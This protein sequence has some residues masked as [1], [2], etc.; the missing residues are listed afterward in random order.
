MKKL[1]V[2]LLL[3]A[4]LIPGLEAQPPV[5]YPDYYN[6]FEREG[7]TL[8]ENP[9][10]GWVINT[11]G[12][13]Q[14][15]VQYV[16]AS[17]P[18]RTY[19]R[20]NAQMSFV[21][22]RS[23][24]I[25]ST[26]DTL[27]RLDMRLV[28][29]YAQYPD[30]VAL[31]EKPHYLNFYLPHCG[32]GGVTEVPGYGRI[33]Y[34]NIYPHIDLWV[35]SGKRG[36]KMMFVVHPFGDPAQI[37]MQFT[38]QDDMDVNVN[39]WL[40]MQM[41]ERW[42]ILP[43]AVA[44]QVDEQQNIIPVNWTAEYVLEENDDV[45]GFS[46]DQYDRY[47]PLILLIGPP[48]ASGGTPYTAGVCWSTYFGGSDWDKM[49]GIAVDDQGNQYVTG[50]TRSPW[51]D[52]PQG[53]GTEYW[54]S[55]ESMFLSKFGT[56]NE[57]LWTNFFGG[58]SGDQTS[59]SVAIRNGGFT[60]VFI[61]GITDALDVEA[62]PNGDA[63]IDYSGSAGDNGLLASFLTTNGFMN[64]LTY[65]GNGGCGVRD[66]AIDQAGQ[67]LAVGYSSGDLPPEDV[68][69]P[70]GSEDWT[71]G[72]GGVDGWIAKF[73]LSEEV[74]WSTFVG[75]SARDVGVAVASSNNKIIMTGG[76]ES[77]SINN[78]D[79]GNNAYFQPTSGG[80]GS[81]VFI[82]EFN[83]NGAQQWGTFFGGSSDDESGSG[84]LAIDP[85]NGDVFIVGRTTSVN[86]QV[87]AGSGWYDLSYNGDDDGFIAQFDGIDR[88]PLWISYVGETGEDLLSGIAV[89]EG[90]ICLGGFSN[91]AEPPL[92]LIE[93]PG[94]YWEET[95]HGVDDGLILMFDQNHMPLWGTY[96]GGD[97]NNPNYEAVEH[98]ALVD[99]TDLYAL[100]RT[101]AVYASDLGL[102]FPLTNPQNGAW[103]DEVFDAYIDG[104]VAR[105]CIEQ[106]GIGIS[107]LGSSSTSQIVF[108][109]QSRILFMHGLSEG[110]H[111][112]DVF[113][114]V[115]RMVF[116][117]KSLLAK[118]T[119]SVIIPGIASG[120]YQVVLDQRLSI[121]VVILD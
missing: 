12:Q 33:V 20:K 50:S 62:V 108:D 85:D 53:A 37:Q 78:E 111:Q 52:F 120:R 23:D 106:T 19:I 54:S 55:T 63:F 73:T 66:V 74:L 26:L 83:L 115:G 91:S 70:N 24:T 58:T 114:A 100:G 86:L 93:Y 42:I 45:V 6:D 81:E 88:A 48:P 67:L 60:E 22:S 69:P 59:H 68:Q 3:S 38:G 29:D 10:P 44:Y 32:Q 16:A 118:A 72:G 79:P 56:V 105:F 92:A 94:L 90:R 18:V 76:T 25:A 5:F 96:F 21:I 104:F 84:G 46:F 15:D 87:E 9:N 112:L 99:G 34:E 103:F 40:R 65:F 77:S 89:G 80:G 82:K 97:D 101:D 116:T 39:G 71:F 7:Y 14:T 30:A 57:L 27:H 110:P 4:C 119:T 2:A 64:W 75:G 121:V 31:E 51:S 47:K 109:P 98:L 95:M 117:S 36:Q 8:W 35:Y 102:F 43:E 107:D 13:L 49:N 113:D 41:Q 17:D 28:G 11:N 61:G 1:I